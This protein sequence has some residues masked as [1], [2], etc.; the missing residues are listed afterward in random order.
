MNEPNNTLKS[1]VTCINY[2]TWCWTYLSPCNAVSIKD[3][4]TLNFYV[5][6]LVNVAHVAGFL[7]YYYFEPPIIA[8]GKN[9]Q[10]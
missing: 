7:Y 4:M 8:V 2:H 9:T 1:V 10:S 5:Y 3:I 6:S